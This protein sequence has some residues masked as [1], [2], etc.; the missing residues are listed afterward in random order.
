MHTIFWN[1]D[2]QYDFMRDDELYHGLLYIPGAQ[3]IESNLDRL[4][5]LAAQRGIIV[6][7]TADW[8]DEQSAEISATP[9]FKTTFPRH[10]MI[11]TPGAAYVPATA[12]ARPYIIDWR[13]EH[14]DPAQV[15]RH[16]NIVLYKDAFDIFAG[17]RHADP[18]LQLLDP[19]RVIVYGVATN[20]CVDRAVHGLRDRG[21]EV[22]VVQDAIKELP[23][24]LE[25]TLASWS[26]RS[27]HLIRTDEVAGYL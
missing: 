21:K 5:K 26:A 25:Q 3:G 23:G 12:P 19:Q 1:V 16:R 17:S 15:L 2:T 14:I 6:V 7:N 8:H 13:D 18:A 22:S 24:T 27:V 11:G 4:T 10:C 9:D 20:V